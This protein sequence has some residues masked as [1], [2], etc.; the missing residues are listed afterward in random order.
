[1]S[2]QI[3]LV[4]C[5]AWGRYILRDLGSLGRSVAVVARS[6]LS[7]ATAHAGGAT[8]VVRSIEEL[9]E[10]DGIVVATPTST[11]AAVV[12]EALERGVPVFVEKP[13]TDDPEAADR[14]AS[15]A[16]ERLF[17]MDKW[18]YHPGIQLLA[19]IARDGELGRVIGLRT[20]RN[21]WG[22]PHRDV[23]AIWILAPHDLSIALEV[24]GALPEPR[25]AVADSSNGYATGLV[26]FLGG[27]PWHAVEVSSRAIVRRREIALVC[28]QGIAVLSDGY[29]DRVQIVRATD[30]HDPTMPEPEARPIS[31]EFPLLRELRVFVEYLG[32]GSPPRSSAAEGAAIVRAI[33]DLRRLAGLTS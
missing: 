12:S 8:T 27:E 2:G 6:E 1:V 29:D 30:P 7:S 31:T 21:G 20:T 9:P 24:L 33:S 11:H 23:D 13:L 28:E 3:G 5:G 15:A 32:G 17:V 16:P 22:N 18:R 25:M 10:V 4:G 14:L 19:G 26:G